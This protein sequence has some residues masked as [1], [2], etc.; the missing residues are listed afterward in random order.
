[1]KLANEEAA[2]F[3]V[4]CPPALERVIARLERLSLRPEFV[5]QRELALAR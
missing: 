4:A 3:R 2:G 5:L 1:M